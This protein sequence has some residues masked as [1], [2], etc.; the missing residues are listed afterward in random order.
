M[1][2][3]KLILSACI[4]LASMVAAGAAG[5]ADAY[6]AKPIKVIV[7]YPAGGANDLVARAIG[8]EMSKDLGQQVVVENISGAAGTIGA[9]SAA[10][11]APDGYTLFM[12]AGAHALAPSVRKSLPYDIVSDFAPV[13]VAAIGSY[14]LVVNPQIKANSVK[15]LIDLAKASP[16]TLTFASSGVGA[17][18][19]LAGVLFQERTGTRLHHIPFRG[20]ADAN[21]AV[22]AGH[23]DMIFGS[24]GPTVPHI[25]GGK[26]RALAVTGNARSTALPDVPTLQEA[27]VPDYNVSTWWGLLA[28]AGTP[29]AIVDKLARS[30]EKA[31]A[32]P[33][34]KEQFVN[35]GV[36]AASSTPAEFAAFIKAEVAKFKKITEAA[37]IE[38]Q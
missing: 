22:L 8:Q 28:P 37:G 16:G 33:H 19:H 23:V 14:V 32:L 29:P 31:A 20:D 25:R 5:A 13:S 15:E 3:H 11:A 21:T 6:P 18:P 34:I 17:P 26:V 2:T 30:V 9:A 10:K 24:L 35:M 1:K 7:G 27:G 38:P 4:G 36:E 12:G